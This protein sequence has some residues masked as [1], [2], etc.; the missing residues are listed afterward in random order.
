[1][2]V[3]Y[4][5]PWIP[6]EWIKAHGLEPRGIWLAQNLWLD[7]LPLSAGVCAFAEAAV[8][9]ARAQAD[10][11]VI[12]TTTCD[13]LRR[14]FD[15]LGVAGRSRAFLF[16]IPAT[17]QTPAAGRI[18]RSEV[19]RLGQFLQDLGGR[20]PSPQR[21]ERE[22]MQYGQARNRL[23]AAAPACTS[24]DFAEAV[25]RFHWDG[26]IHLPVRPATPPADGVPL[27]IVGGPLSAPQWNL[28]E[29]IEAMGG[30]VVLNATET[31]ERSLGP[32]F[33]CRDS[34]LE[35]GRAD[36]STL[37]RAATEDEPV[38]PDGGQRVP[39]TSVNPRRA[40]NGFADTGDPLSLLVRGC[41]ENIVD[42]FQKPNTRLYSWLKDRLT[43]RQ[44][45]GIVLWQFTGCDLWR[46]E[47][48]TLREMF[49]LPVLVLEADEVQSCSPR[50]VNR[51]QAFV[52][53]LK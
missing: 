6:A 27:A 16:N 23:L 35:P 39:T 15:A 49:G 41:F 13:Q 18:Y 42:V 47:A 24:R 14:G 4:T 46:A 40:Q 36:L 8:G 33:G 50:D 31:G 21:L 9:F 17:W 28:L 26:S 38:D 44:V 53:T 19:E 12:F 20:V 10:A 1:M 3:C 51:I 43:L 22:M 37:R 30:R 5:S 32:A 52:E 29:V 2:Q 45:R 48:Q 7:S 11:A 25:A 34:S